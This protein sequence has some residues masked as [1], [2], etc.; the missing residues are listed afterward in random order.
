MTDIK[1]TI[2]E[3]HETHGDYTRQA[4]TATAIREAMFAAPN[5]DALSDVQHDALLMIAVKVSRILN[6]DPDLH[7][8]WWDI[9][10]YATLVADRLRKDEHK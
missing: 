10:G 8:S 1:R 2:Q 3:R 6:G 5:W 4:A 7:D 9:A